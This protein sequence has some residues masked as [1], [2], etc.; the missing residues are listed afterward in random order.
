MV[1]LALNMT[2]SGAYPSNA[3]CRA[4]RHSVCCPRSVFAFPP[5]ISVH[6]TS[7]PGSHVTSPSGRTIMARCVVMMSQPKL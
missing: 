2:F 1:G 3:L 6:L 5:W 7:S 4:R